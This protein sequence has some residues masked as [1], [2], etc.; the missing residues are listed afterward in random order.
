[1][2]EGHHWPTSKMPIE[3]HFAGGPIVAQ[4]CMLAKMVWIFGHSLSAMELKKKYIFLVAFN[5]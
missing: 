4:D 2:I 3:W 5:C 1:M